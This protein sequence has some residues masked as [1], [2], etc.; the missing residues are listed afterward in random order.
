L[1]EPPAHIG[2]DKSRIKVAANASFTGREVLLF[3]VERLR[4]LTPGIG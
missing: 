2:T 4:L 3:E 1:C